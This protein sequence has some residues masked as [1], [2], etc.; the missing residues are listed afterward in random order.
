[1]PAIRV[2]KQPSTTCDYHLP[3]SEHSSFV[4]AHSLAHFNV[5]S[6]VDLDIG[7]LNER[8]SDYDG[9]CPEGSSD[10]HYS[11]PNLS[12][13]WPGATFHAARGAEPPRSHFRV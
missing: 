2:T 12:S 7:L 3:K 8:W 1:M 11:T 5:N 4:K 6:H 13:S 10:V 9:A